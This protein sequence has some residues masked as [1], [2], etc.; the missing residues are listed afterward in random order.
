MDSIS[1]I[2]NQLLAHKDRG[3]IKSGNAGDAK[4]ARQDPEL[5]KV[6]KEMESLFTH[7]LIKVMREASKGLASE[8]KGLGQD[9]YMG[10]FDMEVARILSERGLGLQDALVKQL[11]RMANIQDPEK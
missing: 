4:G 2:T 9:T 8:E 6:A 7:Q 1:T 5:K 11:E 10:M 3:E